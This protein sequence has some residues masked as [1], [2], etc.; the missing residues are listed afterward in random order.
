MSGGSLEASSGND[1]FE[2]TGL[3]ALTANEIGFSSISSVDALG[4]DDSV[5]GA[6][7]EDWTLTGNDYEATNNGITFS[8][9]ENLIALNADLI[10]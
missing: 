8:S 10:G 3:N 5:T 7:G 1:S 4:G 9:V 6:D 2:V